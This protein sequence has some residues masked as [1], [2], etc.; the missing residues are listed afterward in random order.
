V[1]RAA[2]AFALVDIDSIQGAV[3]VAIATLKRVPTPLV[4]AT[5][6]SPL[7]PDDAFALGKWGVDQLLQGP[8]TG[9]LLLAELDAANRAPLP[10]VA[11]VIAPYVGRVGLMEFEDKARQAFV[12]QAINRA[13]E[14]RSK[15][16]RILRVARP[17]V[18]RRLPPSRVP[19]E[20]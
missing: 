18:Q 7:S 12:D 8:L 16:A 10:D 17:I 6:E 5:H 1:S 3:W 14:N 4:F 15:A 20:A 2:I 13:L 9:E 11:Q 19:T